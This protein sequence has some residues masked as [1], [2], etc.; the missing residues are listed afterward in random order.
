MVPHEHVG[1]LELPALFTIPICSIAIGNISKFASVAA[2]EYVCIIELSEV[3][4]LVLVVIE[5]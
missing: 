2:H 3:V 5:Y 4:A 1:I